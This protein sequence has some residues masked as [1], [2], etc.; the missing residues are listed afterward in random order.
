VSRRPTPLTDDL[1]DY[2]LS[3]SL[4]EP[5]CLAR[6]RRET[7]SNPMAFMQALPETGQLLSLLVRLTGARRVVEVGTFMGYSALWM[8]LALP[9]RGRLVTLDINRPWNETARRY[10]KEAGVEGRIDARLSPALVELPRLI[11]EGGAGRYDLAFLDADKLNYPAYYEHLMA[12]LRPGGLLVADNVLWGGTA[13]DP[14]AKAAATSAIREFNRR[15]CGDDRIFLSTL[16]VGDGLTL[17]L[18]KDP[19][20]GRSRGGKAARLRPGV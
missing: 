10:W 5:E 14:R 2:L 1:Y 8:A 12:L 7:A 18:K 11:D 15:L 17:A 20:A 4:R 3:I 16:P 6:L 19:R 9:P 13:A